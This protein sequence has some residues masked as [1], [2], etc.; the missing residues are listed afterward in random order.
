[1]CKYLPYI[2][3][4]LVLV[5][6][7][8]TIYRFKISIYAISPSG[9]EYVITKSGLRE[10]CIKCVRKHIAQARVLLDE[11]QLGYPNHFFLALGHLAE[12]ESESVKQYPTLAKQIREA[13]ENIYAGNESDLM[14][15][16]DEVNKIAE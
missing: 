11:A 3:L 14:K 13:R 8:Y 1:M 6:I 10:S 4:I 9:N 16:L 12:A 2:V 7:L 5:L 15:L